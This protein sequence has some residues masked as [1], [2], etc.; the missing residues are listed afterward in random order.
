MHAQE[1][2][3][4][5][6]RDLLLAQVNFKWL[7]SGLG[8]WVDMSRFRTDTSYADHLLMLGSS[9]ESAALRECAALL[10]SQSEG[11]RQ[12]ASAPANERFRQNRALP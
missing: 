3:S 6:S 8:W 12:L 7:M 9:A 1:V 10:R 4:I 5:D 11:Q 2:P